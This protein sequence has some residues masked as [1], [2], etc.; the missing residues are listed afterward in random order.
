[1]LFFKI[2][3]VQSAN[4]SPIDNLF[5]P[6]SLPV[7]PHFLGLQCAQLQGTKETAAFSSLLYSQGWPQARVQAVMSEQK[8][9]DRVS[10]TMKATDVTGTCSFC[11]FLSPLL[12]DL[13][14][15]WLRLQVP[16]W[17]HE[18]KKYILKVA[19]QKLKC[20]MCH[21]VAMAVLTYP[22]PSCLCMR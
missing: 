20:L 1:M 13:C 22:A 21:E 2:D 16:S 14:T 11:P 7:D 5:S 9:L 15:G 3:R 18:D 4:T 19:K 17:E 8:G 6:S 12:T 10:K